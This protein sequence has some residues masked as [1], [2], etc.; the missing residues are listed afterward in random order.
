MIITLL[1]DLSTGEV[2]AVIVSEST[3][4]EQIQE[5]INNAKA[6]KECEW[7]WDD[8]VECLPDDCNIVSKWSRELYEIVY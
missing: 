8:L 5:V 7:Q 2:D 4:S 1:K 6:E 3:S